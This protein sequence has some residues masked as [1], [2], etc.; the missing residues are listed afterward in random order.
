[1]MH[2]GMPNS[3]A[4][5]E[6]VAYGLLNSQYENAPEAEQ[7]ARIQ[8]ACVRANADG[9]VQKLPQGLAIAEQVP[10]SALGKPLKDAARELVV[11]VM[12]A[13]GNYEPS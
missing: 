1:M 5:R 9:F 2:W 7:F 3:G 12:Q 13:A 10:I 4:V 6:N 11:E 8:K